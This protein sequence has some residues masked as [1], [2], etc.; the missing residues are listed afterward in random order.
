MYNYFFGFLYHS[1]YQVLVFWRHIKCLIIKRQGKDMNVFYNVYIFFAFFCQMRFLCWLYTAEMPKSKLFTN[2]MSCL[3]YVKT[4]G[5]PWGHPSGM[6]NK[7]EPTLFCEGPSLW[8]RYS[9][10]ACWCGYLLDLVNLLFI[11]SAFR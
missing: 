3:L 11:S 2:R 7:K 4:D 10:I 6:Y 1:L 5:M 8:K 9:C